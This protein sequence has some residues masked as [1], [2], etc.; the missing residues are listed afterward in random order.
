MVTK[1]LYLSDHICTDF[2]CRIVYEQNEIEESRQLQEHFR[3]HRDP[4]ELELRRWDLESER[5]ADLIPQF[6]R[7]TPCY[8]LEINGFQRDARV[9]LE[10]DTVF[11]PDALDDCSREIEDMIRELGEHGR[12]IIYRAYKLFPHWDVVSIWS[13]GAYNKRKTFYR[14]AVRNRYDDCLCGS[15]REDSRNSADFR[16]RVF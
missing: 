3:R 15:D 7:W 9:V 6:Q 8:V 12:Y 5:L 4:V 10:R 16:R 11:D 14:D 2:R 1:K 13:I